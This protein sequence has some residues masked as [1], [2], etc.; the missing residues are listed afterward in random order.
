M[1]CNDD[2]RAL[3]AFDILCDVSEEAFQYVFQSHR[4][5]ALLIF[6]KL[7]LFV[8]VDGDP[9]DC[10]ALS[11]NVSGSLSSRL[12]HHSSVDSV[13][14][15]PSSP[16]LASRPRNRGSPRPVQ[17]TIDVSSP[18]VDA[19]PSP[20]HGGH[21]VPSPSGHEKPSK[22]SA[23]VQLIEA[24]NEAE[25]QIKGFLSKSEFEATK[26]HLGRENGDPR[27]VDLK[28]GNKPSHQAIYRKGL[29]QR[30]LGLEYEQWELRNHRSSK[31]S[32]LMQHSPISNKNGL[33][34]TYLKS[35][36]YP[37]EYHPTISK[38]LEHGIKLLVF[39]RMFGRKAISAILSFKY[40]RFRKVRF[41]DLAGL[42]AMMNESV[43]LTKLAEEKS[44]W[45]DGCQNMYDGT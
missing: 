9:V 41:E 29:C 8:G 15:K 20:I 23:T 2:A 19:V 1:S 37:F 14:S 21:T 31:I 10:T 6:G 40:H 44:N 22:S 24:L 4:A 25:G 28:M 35:T 42:K 17:N 32:E 36:D 7:H 30:S 3:E 27:L 11:E 43:W 16:R 45:L 12:S 39:E 18:A 26:D 34:Q 33:I 5:K 38:G 13:R